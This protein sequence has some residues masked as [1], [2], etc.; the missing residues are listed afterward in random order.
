MENTYY[1]YRVKAY[2]ST[3]ESAFSDPI[4][5]RRGEDGES[6]PVPQNVSATQGTDHSKITITWNAVTGAT[7][8]KLY[9]AYTAGGSAQLING[10][11]TTTNYDDTAISVG[12]HYFY[13]VVAVKGTAQSGYSSP[14]AEGWAQYGLSAPAPIEA[15]QAASTTVITVTWGAVSGADTYDLYMSDSSQG[16]YT[17]VASGITTTSYDYTAPEGILFFKVK[18]HSLAGQESDYSDFCSGWTTPQAPSKPTGVVATDGLYAGTVRVSWNAT[19]GASYYTV[20]RS[21]EETGTWTQVGGDIYITSY[22]DTPVANGSSSSGYYYYRVKAHNVVGASDNSDPD[23]GWASCYL[24]TPGSVSATDGTS[25]TMVTVTWSAV[26]KPNPTDPDVQYFVERKLST[27]PDTSY[28][29][30]SSILTSTSFNDTSGSLGV[31]YLY[32]VK[33]FMDTGGES[34]YSTPDEGYTQSVPEAP[35]GISATDGTHADKVVI[36]WTA[37]GG[38]DSYAV[39][40]YTNAGCTAD[41]TNIPWSAGTSCEDASAVS[42][43]TYYYKVRASNG[44]GNSSWSGA[45]SGYILSVPAGLTASD[46]SIDGNITVSWT[47]ALGAVSYEIWRSSDGTDYGSSAYVS[48]HTTT[49]Y[50]DAVGNSQSY[51]YKVK[52]VNGTEVSGF[53]N[54]DQGT[55]GTP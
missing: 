11:L 49:S 26:P 45:D 52:A 17:Q 25:G 35:T 31:H 41:E 3:G 2:N 21:S 44:A 19:A 33:A 8:Y 15:S 32:R 4:Q 48:G 16:L 7:G 42:G 13:K 22:N 24:S 53:S 46:G 50:V 12:T 20:E 30:V 54:A 43:T 9:R 18:A 6:V 36:S 5:G 23:K 40:R 14:V 37:S 51:Y 10:S 27:D 1:Y 39:Y 28:V 29:I 38:A 34:D 55:T 47:A